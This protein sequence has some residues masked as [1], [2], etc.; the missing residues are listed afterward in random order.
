MKEVSKAI[1]IDRDGI[2]NKN[3]H[4]VNN[5]SDFHILPQVRDSL[6]LLK[7]AGYKIIIIT[8]QGGISKG[9]IKELILLEIHD[10]MLSE[11]PEIDD[12]SY[13]SDYDS[14]RRKPNPGMVYE[15]A[16]KH[17]INIGE[18]W[19]IGDMFTDIQCGINA[20]CK[21]TAMVI[22]KI[23]ESFKAQGKATII[24]ESLYQAVI[25]ILGAE[26]YLN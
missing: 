26:G 1:F 8:N 12:I 19:F 7:Q 21:G 20:G 22:S 11:L 25:A 13:C 2:I 15:Q 9:F 6:R 24:E 23:Q 4:Y 18:S 14:F 10:H 16:M 3:T 17:N 5:L